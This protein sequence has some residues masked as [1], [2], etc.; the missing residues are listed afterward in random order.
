[1]TSPVHLA[2]YVIRCESVD[3][4]IAQDRTENTMMD[5]WVP[6]KQIISWLTE[7]VQ[8]LKTLSYA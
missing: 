5:V 3:T 6:Y 4:E 7:W 1:M 8:I 2:D